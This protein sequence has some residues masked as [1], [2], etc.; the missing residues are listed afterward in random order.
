LWTLL[1]AALAV[2]G[3]GP[4][5]HAENPSSLQGK[6]IGVAVLSSTHFWTQ[7]V[8]RGTNEAIE[9]FGG[10]AIVVDGQWDNQLHADNH[11]QLLAD[12][13]DAVISILGDEKVEPKLKILNEAD[14]PILTVDHRSPH[15]I[16]NTTS[17]NYYMGT[18][19]GRLMADAIGGK[20]NVALFNAFEDVLRICEIRAKLWKFVMEDYPDIKI[21][22]PELKE[23]FANASEDA[24]V[25]TL[26]LLERHPVGELDAIHIGCWDQPAIG[27]VQALQETGRT[28]IMVTGIDAG[29]D[30][31]EIMMKDN[32]PFVANVA[33][34]PYKIGYIAAT[35]VARFFAGDTLLPQTFVDVIPVEGSIEAEAVYETLGYGSI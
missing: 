11:D 3:T 33:Q 13:V 4:S 25:K 7:E 6:R 17:D 9:D 31:L 16:N 8:L 34:Q 22:Q 5:S 28:E 14:I 2:L 15:A 20:G 1:L 32:S 10:E 35:N 30:T 12:D 21:L 19:I 24:R 23:T 27:V 26:D 18:T 29:P